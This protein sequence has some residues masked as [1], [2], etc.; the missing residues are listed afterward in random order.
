M[1]N[2]AIVSLQLSIIRKMQIKNMMFHFTSQERQKCK[3][4]Q[5]QILARV[6]SKQNSH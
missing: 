5:C 4:C 6:W 1:A 2:T 3:D